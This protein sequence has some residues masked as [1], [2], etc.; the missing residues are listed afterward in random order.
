MRAS[1]CEI[2]RCPVCRRGKLRLDNAGRLTVDDGHLSCVECAE[3]FPVRSGIPIFL[4]G[5]LLVSQTDSRFQDLDKDSRQ[6]VLQRQWHDVAHMEETDFKQTSYFSTGLFARL[7]Y[8]QLSDMETILR[9]Q[10]FSTIANVCSGHGHELEFLSLFGEHVVALDISW[11]SLLKTVEMGRK[12]GVSVE[13]IC[14]DAEDLPL[15]DDQ[16]D[17]V[18]THHSLHHLANPWR[19]VEEIVRIS[20]G[21]SIFFE[22]AKGI[23]RRVVTMLGLKPEVEESGNIVY[24]FGKNEVE[25]F[26]RDRGLQLRHFHKYLVTGPAHEPASFPKLDRLGISALILSLV[27]A[28]NLLLGNWLGT[29]CSV[30]IEKTAAPF[31]ARA[32]A[33]STYAVGGSR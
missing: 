21:S 33:A 24:E 17:L 12:I 28:S 15:Q 10:R 7:L 13:G 20:R 11:A 23:T 22:P 6:K 16:F 30:V 25:K 31:E 1:T 29:K 5:D 27:K 19:G 32:T 8:Y 14:C 2:L 18:L 3:T 4:R 9:G 26:C